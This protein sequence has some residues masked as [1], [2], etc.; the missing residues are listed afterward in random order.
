MATLSTEG[1]TA[2]LPTG[3]VKTQAHVCSHAAG[4]AALFKYMGMWTVKLQEAQIWQLTVSAAARLAHSAAA[5]QRPM[6][7]HS[8]CQRRARKQPCPH[9][10]QDGPHRPMNELKDS[11]G[12]PAGPLRTLSPVHPPI[13]FQLPNKPILWTGVTYPQ[14]NHSTREA[15]NYEHRAKSGSQIFCCIRTTGL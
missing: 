9:P 11:H 7:T 3:Q 4:Q 13:R 2:Y 6:L 12:Q 14:T 8:C 10:L 15:A 5:I 1:T